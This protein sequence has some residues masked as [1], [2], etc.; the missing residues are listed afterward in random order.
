MRLLLDTHVL[1]WWLQ[2]NPRLSVA[3]NTR[4]RT[5]SVIYTSSVS[6][7]EISIKASVGKLNVDMAEL[8]AE[9]ARNGFR[10]LAISH[11]HAAKVRELPYLH[12]D[13][14]DRMLVAQAMCEP[15]TLLTADGVLAGYSNLVEVI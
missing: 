7:W 1:L 8:F 13:P 4:I 15:L 5:A 9:I 10:E 11:R 6:I 2:S 3:A 12:R 14:F